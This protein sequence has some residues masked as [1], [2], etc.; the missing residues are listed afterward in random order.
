MSY[1]HKANG[2]HKEVPWDRGQAE[3]STWMSSN[4]LRT[5]S[6]NPKLTPVL[7]SLHRSM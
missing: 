5:V 2:S 3:N 4:M 7:V 6:C 1:I